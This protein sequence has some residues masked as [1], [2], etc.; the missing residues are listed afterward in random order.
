MKGFMLEASRWMRVAIA[1]ISIIVMFWVYVNVVQRYACKCESVAVEW[2]G[3]Y[4]INL[5]NEKEI[6][7]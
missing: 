7:L 6:I 5:L 3:D 2:F 1:L 4:V